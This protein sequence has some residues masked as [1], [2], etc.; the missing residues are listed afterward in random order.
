MSIKNK[1][2]VHICKIEDFLSQDVN[3]KFCM[4]FFDPPFDDLKFFYNLE[5]IRKKK[6]FK[7]NHIVIIHRESKS[8]NDF[9]KILKIMETKQYGRS[10]IIFAEFK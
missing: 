1:S 10:K 3:E 4:F 2:K 6:I 5:L 8:K 9:K 7:K